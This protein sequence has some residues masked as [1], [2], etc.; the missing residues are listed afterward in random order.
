[1]NAPDRLD[2]CDWL[3][4][5]VAHYPTLSRALFVSGDDFLRLAMQA[6]LAARRDLSPERG[7]P[8]IC[9]EGLPAEDDGLPWGCARDFSESLLFHLGERLCLHAHRTGHF[10]VAEVQRARAAQPAGAGRSPA[11]KGHGCPASSPAVGPAPAEPGAAQPLDI[12]TPAN[13][14]FC[15]PEV[16]ELPEGNPL[17]HSHEMPEE[18]PA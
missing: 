13:P 14:L 8:W 12:T 1:M 11:D 16:Q 3:P 6:W 7:Q 9:R 15:G 5:T 2:L 17:P 4:P 18:T 10:V